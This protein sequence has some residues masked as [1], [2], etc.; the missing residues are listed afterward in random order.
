MSLTWSLCLC[1]QC[2]QDKAAELETFSVNP[3][4]KR[5][6]LSGERELDVFLDAVGALPLEEL[7]EEGSKIKLQELVAQL[8]SSSSPEVQALLNSCH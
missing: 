2:A 8:S 1:L 4:P 6:C 5:Q 7:G 3:Q